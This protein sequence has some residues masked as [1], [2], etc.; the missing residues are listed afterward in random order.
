MRGEKHVYAVRIFKAGM[1]HSLPPWEGLVRMTRD[2][3]ENLD[4]RCL[5]AQSSGEI[6]T[7]SIEPADLVIEFEELRSKLPPLERDALGYGGPHGLR[8]VR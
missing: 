7:Y 3:R 5:R 4:A 1:V 6:T 2:E 8:R